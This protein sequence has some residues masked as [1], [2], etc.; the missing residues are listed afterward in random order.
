MKK[1]STIKSIFVAALSALIIVLPA[2]AADVNIVYL[3]DESGSMAG[4]HAFLQT[5]VPQLE[6]DL[7]GIQGQTSSFGLVGFGRSN[8]APR[9]FNVGAGQ[10]GSA[11]DFVTAANGLVTSGFFEDGYEAIQHALNNFTFDSGATVHFV[12]VT[13]ED[14]DITAGSANTFNSI[15]TALSAADIGL[16]SIL[17]QRFTSGNGTT[18]NVTDFTDTFIHD[19]AGGFFT[20]TGVNIGAASGSTTADY[21]DLA[22]QLNGCVMDL[23]ELRAGGGVSQGAAAAFLN[24]LAT[25]GININPVLTAQQKAYQTFTKVPFQRVFMVSR[26]TGLA[27]GMT[28]SGRLEVRKIAAR[29]GQ[30]VPAMAMNFV[31]SEGHRISSAQMARNH[32]LTGLSGGAASADTRYASLLN[33]GFNHTNLA[34]FVGGQVDFGEISSSQNQPF[35]SDY[36]TFTVNGGMDYLFGTEYLAG[37]GFGYNESDSDLDNNIAGYQSTGYNLSLYGSYFPEG[38]FSADGVFTY[39]WFN[40]DINISGVG[41]ANNVDSSQ[42]HGLLSLLYNWEFKDTLTAGPYLNFNYSNLDVDGYT[43]GG[44]RV[45]SDSNESITLE[46][47]LNAQK[48]FHFKNGDT[49]AFNVQSGL[50]HDFKDGKRSVKV[51]GFNFTVDGIA[52]DYV[53]AGFGIGYNFHHKYQVIANYTSMISNDII[54]HSIGANIRIMLD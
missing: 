8:P 42:Y 6:A 19:G 41:N 46:F 16:S 44:N 31:N 47:G 43:V 50:V 33:Q 53:R 15:F 22:R 34:F 9:I 29:R 13:D 23:N 7:L 38:G 36:T 25:R 27:V 4:E 17:N 51:N 20:E 37:I 52:Q 28:Y 40:N 18:G 45:G 32:N 12:L 54:N 14:R 49:L 30:D 10:L 26:Q 48:D 5:H 3:V 1:S 24:C 11:A 39:T 21:T 2:Q 35:S